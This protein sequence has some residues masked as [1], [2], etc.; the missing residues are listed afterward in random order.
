MGQTCQNVVGCPTLSVWLHLA[1]D[2][3]T[4]SIL[5]CIGDVCALPNGKL[6][7][8][9][10]QKN[11]VPNAQ[12]SGQSKQYHEDCGEGVDISTL[13]IGLGLIK[14]FPK[15]YILGSCLLLFCV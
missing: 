14:L 10:V 2:V 13:D 12:S 15:F 3:G 11:C 4:F 6:S 1:D 8:H 9:H 7:H 5:Q